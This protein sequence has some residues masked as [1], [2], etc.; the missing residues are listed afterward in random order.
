MGGKGSKKKKDDPGKGAKAPPTTS[1][2]PSARYKILL[3]GDSAVGKSSMLLRFVD[4]TF[5]DSFISNIGSDYKEKILDNNKLQ[6][7]DTGGQERFRTITSSFYQGA[8]GV[9]VLYDI[10]N[11]ETW[12]SVQKWVQEVDRYAPEAAKVLVGN[13]SDLAAE[14]QVPTDEAREYA[15][16][17]DIPYFE[18]SAR[19]GTCIE[20][21]FKRLAECIKEKT[22]DSESA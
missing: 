19:E 21:A 18:T 17:L 14:R 22:D 16:S 11:Q 4:D 9:I 12:A 10:T 5:S 8:H 20:Q 2:A 7:W 1:Q 13:K 6:I 3:I 15:D